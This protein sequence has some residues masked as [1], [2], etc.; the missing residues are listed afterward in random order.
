MRTE[1]II[2]KIY[3]YSELSDEAKEVVKQWYIDNFH[4][5]D[6]FSELVVQDLENLFGKNDLLIEYSLSYCQGDGFNIYGKITAG[7]IF[8]CIHYYG[9]HMNETLKNYMTEEEKKTIL[10]YDN[11]LGEEYIELP[12][13]RRYG[14]CMADSIDFAED[15]KYMLETYTDTKNIDME[16]LKKFESLVRNLFKILCGEYEKMG[17]EYF[18]EVDDW[19]VEECCEANEYEFLEDGTFYR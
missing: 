7:K 19:E 15:W 17:Y 18:Y 8:N 16:T 13:N 2:R 12:C 1:T 11:S 5:S 9:G 4:T 14:Y 6:D 3:T 10:A